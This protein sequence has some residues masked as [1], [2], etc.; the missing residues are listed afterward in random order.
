M[1]QLVTGLPGA[2]KTLNTIAEIDQAHGPSY[3]PG[4]IRG[5]LERLRIVKLPKRD[6]RPIYYHGIEGL[7]LD[8][9]QKFE[10]PQA[11]PELP[12]GSVIV[13]D[14]CQTHWPAR[15]LS[16]DKPQAVAAIETHR[17]HGFDLYFITQD[18]MLVDHNIR[19]LCNRYVHFW[20]PFGM[21]RSTRWEWQRFDKP[22]DYHFRKEV[23][24]KRV[25]SLPKRYF[26]AY[27]SA[28]VHTVKR[29]LPVKVLAFPALA[30]VVAAL[31]WFFWRSMDS[32][33]SVGPVASVQAA[34]VGPNIQPV[35]PTSAPGP[36]MPD[37]E[38]VGVVHRN[39]GGIAI[40]RAE[41]GR[42]RTVSLSACE[43][44]DYGD[45]VC[46]V[47]G[48]SYVETGWYRYDKPDPR[49]VPDGTHRQGTQLF[50]SNT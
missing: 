27:K 13:V 21:A 31:F 32:L 44:D 47:R 16:K 36:V 49:P 2:G 34:E 19:K 48:R 12:A 23:S 5:F 45:L 8:G 50:S 4:K 1:L 43:R 3:A 6:V 30:L 46:F 18:G 29:K 7:N 25:V 9:W 22:T 14:E 41:D 28:E 37:G 20:R 39:E 38:I 11:W 26:G 10:D 15:G 40:I 42:Q 33:G 35:A 24:S 17:H